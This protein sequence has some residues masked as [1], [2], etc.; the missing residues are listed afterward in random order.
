MTYDLPETHDGQL[1]D[2]ED[3]IHS[4]RTHS[5]SP[6]AKDVAIRQ[7]RF[8][9]PYNSRPVQVARRFAGDNHDAFHAL[10]TTAATAIRRE[11]TAIA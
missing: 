8:Q 5:V 3:K 11:T 6:D 9:R 2:V 1:T 4:R 7:R 10:F